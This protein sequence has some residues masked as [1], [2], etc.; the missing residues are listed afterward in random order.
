MQNI[1]KIKLNRIIANKMRET[2]TWKLQLQLPQVGLI[3]KP[4]T[5]TV[6]IAEKKM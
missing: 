4:G 2:S 1:L 3:S 5:K 6:H